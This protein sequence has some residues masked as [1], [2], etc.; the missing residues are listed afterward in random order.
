MINI[1]KLTLLIFSIIFLSTVKT[2][3]AHVTVKP[4]SVG[5]AE[6]VNF[7]VSVP[8]EKDMPTTGLRLE[9]PEG[10]KSVRPLVKPGWRV[11]IVKEES[12]SMNEEGGSN[13][14]KELIWTGGSIPADQKDEFVFSA[15]AP[16][17]ET[18]LNWKAHQTYM[19]GSV[20]SWDAEPNS[21]EAE[22][23]DRGPYSRT[24]VIND[25][26]AESSNEGLMTKE[27]AFYMAAAALVFSL[28]S[29]GLTLKKSN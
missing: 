11:Q 5:V 4:E 22:D 16:A 12:D 18:Q 10:L 14:V 20:V 8:T 23:E 6:R 9:I 26:V 19:D 17:E 1:K 27:N 7:T 15:Q 24:G 3:S 28:V 21:S 29:F 2:T 25:L 13:T